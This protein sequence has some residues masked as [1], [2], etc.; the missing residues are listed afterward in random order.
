MLDAWEV[1][2]FHGGGNEAR[3]CLSPGLLQASDRVAALVS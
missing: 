3:Q 1:R 2:I